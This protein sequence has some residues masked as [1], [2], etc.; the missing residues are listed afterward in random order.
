MKKVFYNIMIV[1]AL[2]MTTS[3]KDYLDKSPLSDIGDTDPYKN[4]MNFQGFTDELYNTIPMMTTPD[5]HC[6]WNFGEDEY[7]Q[8][9]ETRMLAYA[10]DHGNNWGWDESYYS[11]FHSGT[12]NPTS[13]NRDNKGHLWGMS[14]YGIR[15]ANVGLAH[16]DLL[17]DATDEEKKLI[18]GQLLFFRGF[19]HFLL[20]QNWGG[21]PYI[22]MEIPADAVMRYPRLNYQQTADKAAEDFQAAADLLPIDWDQTTVGKATLGKNNLRINKVMCLAFL[23]KDLLWAGSPL[24]NKESQGK[25]EYNKEYCKKAAQAF[26]EI[27]KICDETKRYELADFKDYSLLF[28]TFNQN[29]KTPGLKEAIFYENVNNNWRWNMVNDFRPSTLS[30]S[31]IK[32]YP[33][34]NYA[35]YFGMA[36]GKPIKDITKKDAESGYDPEY[37]FRDRDPRFYENFVF[38]GVKCVKAGN[39]VG[40]DPHRQYASLYTGGKYRVANRDKDCFTGYLNMK[41]DS[42]Y[43]NDWDGYRE[44]NQV[45]LSLV[46]LADIYLMY[47]EAVAQGYGSLTATST[48]YSMNPIAAVNKVRAR[49]GVGGIDAEYTGEVDKFMSELRRERAVELA[50]EGHRYNDL[51]RWLLLDKAP[52]N[53][54]TAVYFDR[55]ADQTDAERYENPK[56]NHV[57]NLREEVLFTRQ[58][59]DMHYWFPFPRKDVQMYEGFKQN[60]GWE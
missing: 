50:F 32:C 7:W 9:N 28:Y 19:F 33:T 25:A 40:N 54:K 20:M 46:R 21:L 60:P 26:G 16:L 41:W 23:G 13:T 15:K 36:N 22:D 39:F 24:M 38:D 57:L 49:A 17:Q 55:A 1:A 2:A 11:Y 37:P 8:P 42:Q 10:I 44:N 58:L 4:Y 30:G 18:K 31:G 12:G 51:R 47:A 5:F 6:C 52:Y 35:D 59:S 27:L 56:N 53:K 34:A 43:A 3:C 29:F 45:T 14:W 48:N